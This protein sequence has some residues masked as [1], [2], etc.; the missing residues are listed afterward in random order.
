[1]FRPSLQNKIR[2]I[3]AVF[4]LG[5]GLQCALIEHTTPDGPTQPEYRDVLL[6]KELIADALPPP[7]HLVEAR[8]IALQ[9]SQHTDQAELSALRE[10]WGKLHS[11]YGARQ[12]AWSAQLRDAN[13]RALLEQNHKHAERLFALGEHQLWPAIEAGDQT[14]VAGVLRELGAVYSE[15]RS[16]LDELVMHADKQRE[17]ASAAAV[18]SVQS[19]KLTLLGVGLTSVMIAALLAS[20]LAR[21][22]LRRTRSM[23]E[24]LT[25]VAAGDLA[26]RSHAADAED[27]EIGQIQTSLNQALDAI[28]H[29]FVE[30]HGVATELAAAAGQLSHSTDQISQGAQQQATSLEETAASLEEITAT[31]KQ[32]AGNAQQADRVAVGSRDVA[33]RGGSVVAGAISAMDEI[34][35]A[36]RRIGDII[37]TID[38]IALQTNLLALNAAVE[39]A[40]AGEQGRGFAV[41][42]Q[43]VGNLAQRSAA[44]AK[45]VKALIQDSLER[46]QA[47]HQLVGESGRAL[48]DIIISVKK[49]TD[50]VAEIAAGAREQ[51]IGVDQVNQAVSQ[52]DQVTQSN[53]AQTEQLSQTTQ[54]LAE[55]A[56]QLS[57]LLQ[58][59]RFS[60]RVTRENEKRTRARDDR[61]QPRPKR[62]VRA[63]AG[64]SVAGQGE[65][66][67][68]EP[69]ASGNDNAADDGEFEVLSPGDARSA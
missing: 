61:S 29:V 62:R 34:T 26:Q 66:S 13:L 3:V 21:S 52:M 32:S 37:T 46:I 18:H 30:V 11:A 51:S 38:E 17:Q 54:G 48:N 2:V 33:E 15:Q 10:R 24:T 40:R 4:V 39:A 42:A 16:T 14:R 50:I 31:V 63:S 45:E 64:E 6:M 44:A 65:P 8:L 22:I 59:F 56:A 57:E 47:G 12:R 25:R 19:R 23:S 27:D 49:V 36:S 60:A 35:K 53:A 1:M 68:F 20:A 5:M 9:A 55:N 7:L 69:T 67:R 28:E 41:V 58:R 43:E